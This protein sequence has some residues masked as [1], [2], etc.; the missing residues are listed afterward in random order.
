MDLNWA[1]LCMTNSEQQV[2]AS[3]AQATGADY[4]VL[5]DSL[6][7]GNVNAIAKPAATMTVHYP[8][9]KGS[10][11]I[12]HEIGHLLGLVDLYTSST[13]YLRPCFDRVFSF[14]E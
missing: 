2:L 4:V 7:D 8:K 9:L 11:T 12:A 6:T 5:V 10:F 3:A 14:L 13:T 1:D